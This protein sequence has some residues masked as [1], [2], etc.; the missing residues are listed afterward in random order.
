[1]RTRKKV[2]N[3]E[4]YYVKE[5]RKTRERQNATIV[6]CAAITFGIIIWSVTR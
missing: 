2:R 1:M 4:S 5:A 6:L 3:I